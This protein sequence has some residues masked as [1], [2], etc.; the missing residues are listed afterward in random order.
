MKLHSQTTLH[1]VT[2]VSDSDPNIVATGSG[3]SNGLHLWDRRSVSKGRSGARLMGH[4]DT[5][6]H[7]SSNRDGRYPLSNS[8]ENSAMAKLWDF[9][10]QPSSHSARGGLYGNADGRPKRGSSV[11]SVRTYSPRWTV[12]V[13]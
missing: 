4:H 1:A 5:I 13:V 7:L 8:N 9:R 2:F 12:G 11:V 3:E 10:F 6:I